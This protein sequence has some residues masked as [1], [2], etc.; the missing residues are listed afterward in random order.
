MQIQNLIKRKDFWTIFISALIGLITVAFIV[1]NYIEMKKEKIRMKE[2]EEEQK[3]AEVIKEEE[4]Y[5]YNNTIFSSDWNTF[6]NQWYNSL[7]SKNRNLSVINDMEEKPS[8]LGTRYNGRISNALFVSADTHKNTQKIGYAVVIG[9]IEENN[10]NRNTAVL[11][12][13]VN[14]I[15]VTDP[16]LT[17]EESNQIALQ[18][19]GLGDGVIL[20]KGSLSHSL[21]GIVYEAEYERENERLGT[22]TVSVQ[23]KF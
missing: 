10:M 2:V 18:Y 17:L 9:A 12:A 14:L 15:K 7:N 3:Q 20:Q 11:I 19:L 21:N 1:G 6:K 22:L 16:S 5:S 8:V 4:Q 13:A 23:R